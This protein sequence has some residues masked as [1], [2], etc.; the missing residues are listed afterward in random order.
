MASKR[1]NRE[2][3]RG[4]FQSYLDD[5]GGEAGGKIIDFLLFHL[6]GMKFTVPSG[7]HRSKPSA[8]LP[9]YLV[10]LELMERFYADMRETFGDASARLI[11]GKFLVHLGGGRLTFPSF[12][13]VR[14]L[15]RNRKIRAEYRGNL[16]ELALRWGLSRSA[17]KKIL[18]QTD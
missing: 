12:A 1:S 3:I 13:D 8:H 15:E 5:F 11:M 2:K 14:R 9:N 6:G 16:T 7:N 4:L 10:N 18:G 17:V